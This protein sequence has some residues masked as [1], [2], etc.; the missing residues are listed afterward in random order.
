MAP[1]ACT[2]TGAGMKPAA[3][4]LRRVR[5]PVAESGDVAYQRI[6]EL[7][8][9]RRRESS[10][11]GRDIGALPPVADPARRESCRTDFRLFCETYFAS[12]FSR[13]WSP[14]H[15]R[16]IGKIERSVLRG[17]LFALA[18]PRGSGKSTLS[19]TAAVWC[20]LYAHRGFVM[21]VGATETAA[22]EMLASIKVEL[23]TNQLLSDDFPEVCY[24][25]ARLDG[26]ANRCGGQTCGGVRTRITWTNTEL[27][28]PTVEGSAASGICLRVAGIT[29]RIRGAK[30]KRADGTVVRPDLVIVDDPQTRE[31]AGSLEQNRKLTAILAGDVAGLAGP[32]RKM[33]GIMPCT[34]IRPGDMAEQMLDRQL[35]PE[36]NGEKAKML[37]S[38]PADMELW[39]RYNEIRTDSL[40]LDG[41]ISR[42]TEFYREHREAMDRGAVVGWEERYNPDELSAVQNAMDLFF[43]DPEAFAA[44][45]QNEPLVDELAD[46]GLLSPD[47]ICSR[48][49]GVPRGE[50][51]VDADHLTLFVDVQK[52]MLFWLVAAWSD[53]FSGW[54]VD[55]GEF[56]GQRQRMFSL[57]R[58]NPTL[59]RMFPKAGLEG[60]L[61]AGLREVFAQLM[62]RVWRREDGAEMSIGQALVDANWGDS[63]PVV[64]Q[65]CRTCGYRERAMPSHGKYFGAASKPMSEYRRSPG[66]RVGLN[67]RVP[68]TRGMKTGRHVVY[69]ANFWKSFVHSRLSV[70]AGDPGGLLLYGRRP[71]E[72]ELLA[73]HLTAEYRV[74]TSGRGRCVDEW[75]LRPDRSDNHWL[76]C[77]AGAAVAAS[78]RGCALPEQRGFAARAVRRSQPLPDVFSAP[79]RNPEPPAPARRPSG[80]RVRLSELLARKSA[81]AG[82]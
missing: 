32:G 75:K 37:Y 24:P 66:D 42:A 1:G 40:R 56:P 49:S 13:G 48:L 16:C 17:G 43:F 22:Q 5:R 41:T 70:A 30:C 19:E 8:A 3:G 21:L 34:V 76:D 6:K 57:R 46:G 31:S 81:A 60:Q 71:E 62:E 4:P 27:V 18:M 38:F 29:G 12:A 54:V 52:S 9:R 63:T 64:Y 11:Q 65:F 61:T 77:L 58:A 80:G 28:L 73:E 33:A 35:H 14:D 82:R 51:P 39:N 50:V 25:V 72:H 2:D 10:A 15:L 59:Q 23:E 78:M 36:W 69:D 20:M 45:Y 67:W 26:I 68:N 74:R 79:E 7:A 55:Y 47:E 53:C 44:E